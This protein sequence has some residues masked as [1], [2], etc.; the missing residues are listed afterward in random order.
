MTR[1]FI[2]FFFIEEFVEN[3]YKFNVFLFSLRCK[4]FS[5]NVYTHT[6]AVP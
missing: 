1:I 4:M 3:I 2:L 6:Y 5:V